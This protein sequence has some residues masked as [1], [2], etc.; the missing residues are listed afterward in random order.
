MTLVHSIFTWRRGFLES[1]KTF[2]VDFGH[3]NLQKFP[4][5]KLIYK[6]NISYLGDMTT[7]LQND[8]FVFL[9]LLFGAFE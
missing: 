2:R 8:W 5:R 3:H 6:V 4:G 7:A 1:P 9:K